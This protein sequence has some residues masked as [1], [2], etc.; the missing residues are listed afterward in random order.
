M[1]I[2]VA[3]RKSVTSSGWRGEG[4]FDTKEVVLVEEALNV[5]G[6]WIDPEKVPD[7]GNPKVLFGLSQQQ[8]DTYFS[9]ILEGLFT[10]K[11]QETVKVQNMG[12]DFKMHFPDMKERGLEIRDSQ[13]LKKFLIVRKNLLRISRGIFTLR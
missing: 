7:D 6:L 2:P 9:A 12:K 1:L 4:D 11:T 13:K 8:A 5:S 10:G 3:F